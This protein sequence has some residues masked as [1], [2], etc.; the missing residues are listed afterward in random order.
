MTTATTPYH[1]SQPL[2]VAKNGKMIAGHPHS[3]ALTYSTMAGIA[4]ASSLHT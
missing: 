4:K 3:R 2:V 1:T